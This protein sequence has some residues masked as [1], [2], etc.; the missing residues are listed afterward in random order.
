M[1]HGRKYPILDAG[2]EMLPRKK[3]GMKRT[4]GKKNF[5]RFGGASAA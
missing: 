1:V 4:K 3:K 2:T 5:V